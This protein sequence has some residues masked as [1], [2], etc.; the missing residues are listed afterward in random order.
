MSADASPGWSLIHFS[1]MKLEVEPMAVATYITNNE[2]S[3]E[4][5]VDKIVLSHQKQNMRRYFLYTKSESQNKIP[6]L[7]CAQVPFSEHLCAQNV[8][9]LKLTAI[10]VDIKKGNIRNEII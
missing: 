1:I 3:C 9:F 10:R 2:R 6:V 4:T 8:R 7:L 5:L